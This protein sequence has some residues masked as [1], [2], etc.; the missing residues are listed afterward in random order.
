MYPPT[1][2]PAEGRTET[3]FPQTTEVEF[4]HRTDYW[5]RG[6]TLERMGIE[7]MSVSE[8][9]RYVMEGVFS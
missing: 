1:G 3:D 5:R 6:R 4:I 9:T 2:Q 8:V 7:R